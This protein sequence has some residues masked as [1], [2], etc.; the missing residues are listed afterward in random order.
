[1]KATGPGEAA[2]MTLEIALF[3]LILG[4]ALVSFSLEWVGADVTA[5]A[6]LLLIVLTGLLP[7]D[8]AFASFGSD[9]VILIGS[10]LVLTAAL[11]RTGVVDLAGRAILRHTGEQ[12][13]LLLMVV[14][15]ASAGLGAFMSNTASTAFFLPVIIGLARRAKMSPSRLLLPLAFSSILSSSVTLVSTSTNIVVSG[16]MTGYGMPPMRMFELAPVGIPIAATGLIY[17]FWVGRRLIPERAP[18][19]DPTLAFGTRPYL[20]E[21]VIR[22]GSSLVGKTLAQSGL[23]RELELVVMRVVRRGDLHFAPRADLRLEENDVVLVE[24]RRESI[25]KI[26]DASGID[27]KADVQLGDPSLAARDLRLVEALILPGSPLIGRTLKDSGFGERHNLQVLAI[28]RH[29][30]TLRLKLSEVP[31][32]MGDVMLLQ[33]HR[34]GLTSLEEDGALSILGAVER[35]GLD[36]RR[37]PL[38]TALFVGALACG[39][40]EVLSMPVAVFLGAVLAFATRC[41]NPPEAYREVEWKALIVIGSMLSLGAAM[42]ETGTARFLAGHMVEAAGRYG[43][44]WVL[45]A[46]F[47][48]TVLLTQPMSNQAAAAVVIPVALRTALEL[49]LNGRTFAMMIAVA[50]SCSYLTPLEPSCLMVYGPGNYRFRDFLKVGGPLTLLIYA[51]AVFLVPVVWPL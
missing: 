39:T 30:E 33:G 50:A 11:G 5:L 14:M 38:A 45:T 36:V 44:F 37:A 4:A 29:G 32:R 12:P 7:A 21:I 13:E 49:G 47:W 3:L 27:I 20:T 2:S 17:M 46:F 15:L 6:V 1:M 34:A 26:K 16:L 25:L 43:P 41:I 40:L 31:L 51:I 22:P 24:G 42:E 8:R 9:T 28:H 10:L 18:P 48:L 23:S 35:R 19:A